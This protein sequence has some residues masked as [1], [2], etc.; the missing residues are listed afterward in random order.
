MFCCS[1]LFAEISSSATPTMLSAFIELSQNSGTQVAM[2]EMDL[3]R[4]LISIPEIRR[5]ELPMA[6]PLKDRSSDNIITIYGEVDNRF[7]G[8]YYFH[9]GIDIKNNRLTPVL[10]TGDGEVVK[11]GWDP[12]NF[13]NFILVKHKRGFYSLYSQLDKIDSS[14]GSQVK[15]GELIGH[16][17][18]TGKSMEPHLGYFILLSDDLPIIEKEEDLIEISLDPRQFFFE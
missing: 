9:P 18:N 17:G 10:V 4:V 7:D 8:G 5:R 3:E 14:E 6:Y 11:T 12:E 15:S 1:K 13:G 16:L 2:I